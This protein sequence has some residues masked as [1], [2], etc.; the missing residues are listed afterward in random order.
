MPKI[1]ELPA[2]VVP[3]G[4]DESVPIVQSGDT[5]QVTA[6]N[7]MRGG[8]QASGDVDLGGN[9]LTNGEWDA[10][11]SSLAVLQ[12]DNMSQLIASA[13]TAFLNVRTTGVRFGGFVTVGTG[14]TADITAGAG[15]ILN[16]TTPNAPIYTPIT[17]PATTGIVV[18]DNDTTWIYIDSNATVNVTTSEPSP[19]FRRLNIVLGRAV[20]FGGSVVAVQQGVQPTQQA[21]GAIADIMEILGAVKLKGGLML[22]ANGANLSFDVSSGRILS[23]GAGGA[24]LTP[25]TV[26]LPLASPASFSTILQNGTVVA[27]NGT[28]VIDPANYDNGGVLTAVPGSSTRATIKTLFLFANGRM[29]VAYGQTWYSTLADAK[30]AIR[31]RDFIAI[32]DFRRALVVGWI[33]VTKAATDLTDPAQATFVQ[34]NQ[35]GQPALVTFA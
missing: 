19:A 13:D 16:N 1:T 2:S 18:P 33:C 35:F 9:L 31:T 10:D 11:D 28:T 25:H 3:L 8:F 12:G 7:L 27:P 5:V 15:A 23:S 34:A 24:T 20:A 17:W 21:G 32:D 29:S 14:L 4:G 30:A 22:S 26:E 6:G